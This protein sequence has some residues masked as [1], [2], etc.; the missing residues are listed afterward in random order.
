MSQLP[1]NAST[2]HG[3]N[4]QDSAHR[5]SLLPAVSQR[6]GISCPG[7]SLSRYPALPVPCAAPRRRRNSPRSPA[8]AAT[9]AL[10]ARGWTASVT[11]HHIRPLG[12]LTMTAMTRAR[13]AVQR[14][15]SC[16][17]GAACPP[18]AMKGPFL[19]LSPGPW[20]TRNTS[21]AAIRSILH[22]C[23]PWCRCDG[24]FPTRCRPVPYQNTAAR[25]LPGPQAGTNSP[26]CRFPAQPATVHS[27]CLCGCR[28]NQ[29]TAA[30]CPRCQPAGS[31]RAALSRRTV[32]F[33]LP[34]R[35]GVSASGRCTTAGPLP[36]AGG[37]RRRRQ[38]KRPEEAA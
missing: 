4:S 10:A 18:P 16:P 37:S 13:S 12:T 24:P 27:P 38:K 14:P 15:A 2:R 20:Q 11:S 31:N 21:P 17:K 6:T 23:R 28:D 36:G 22:S 34:C 19:R 9:D 33:P 30:H 8:F 7:K 26:A 5:G 1:L 25:S 32:P 29:H 35:A 3:G